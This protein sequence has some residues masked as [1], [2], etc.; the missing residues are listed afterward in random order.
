MSPELPEILGVGARPALAPAGW[1]RPAQGAPLGGRLPPRLAL[2]R[3]REA[4][5]DLPAVPGLAFLQPGDPPDDRLPADLGPEEQLFV[6][7][8]RSRGRPKRRAG[9]GLNWGDPGF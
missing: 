6:D 1:G 8:W 4:S 9:D 7:A 2:V 5:A 3:P